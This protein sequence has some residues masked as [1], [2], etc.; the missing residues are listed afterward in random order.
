MKTGAL[1]KPDPWCSL[2]FWGKEVIPRAYWYCCSQAK[3]RAHT[4]RLQVRE[5]LEGLD[6]RLAWGK[7]SVKGLV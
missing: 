5:V 7:L 3:T 4:P 1:V 2:F 6:A